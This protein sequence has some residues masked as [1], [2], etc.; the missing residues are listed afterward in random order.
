MEGPLAGSTE[1]T[2]GA[3]AEWNEY[4]TCPVRIWGGLDEQPS[5]GAE[6]RPRTP[7]PAAVRRAHAPGCTPAAR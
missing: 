5:L 7:P 1:A 2:S 3:L 4:G 6:A